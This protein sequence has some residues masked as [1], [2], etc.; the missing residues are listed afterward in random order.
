[1]LDPALQSTFLP[2]FEVARSRSVAKWAMSASDEADVVCLTTD[3][4]NNVSASHRRHVRLWFAERAQ[5]EKFLTDGDVSIEPNNVRVV[6]VLS[7]LDMAALRILDS[8]IFTQF[9]STPSM[10][11]ARR[12]SL[13]A[14]TA[15]GG[16]PVRYLLAHW[17]ILNGAFS[18]R[19]Y[20]NLSGMLTQRALSVADMRRLSGLTLPQIDAFITELARLGSVRKLASTERTQTRSI[21]YSNPAGLHLI[22]NARRSGLLG[23]LRSWFATNVA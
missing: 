5:V 6:A 20:L 7:A 10:L 3:T 17:P 8:S 2:V 9:N 23:R 11:A 13:D 22:A 21:V 14:P 16:E 12:G 1:M 4:S 19:S 15:V 18:T